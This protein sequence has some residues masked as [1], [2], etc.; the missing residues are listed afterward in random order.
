LL[1]FDLQQTGGPR[2]PV[3]RPTVLLADADPFVRTLLHKWLREEFETLS[4]AD[5]AEVLRLVSCQPPD[6]LLVDVALE[7]ISGFEICRS[8]RMCGIQAPVFLLSARI[9]PDE[10]AR[11][12]SLGATDFIAKPLAIREVIERVRAACAPGIGRPRDGV[13][14]A[15]SSPGGD[16][17]G[18]PAFAHVA[19]DAL[20]R[21]ARNRV[22]APDAFRERLA[23]ACRDVVRFGAS[24]GVVRI[25]WDDTSA[26]DPGGWLRGELE[27]LTRPEDLV[28][29]TSAAEAFVV[30]PTESRAGTIGFVRRLRREWASHRDAGQGTDCACPVPSD[31]R[32]GVG[33]VH[34]TRDRRP[35]TPGAVLSAPDP[36]EDL[37]ES[38][39]YA[40]ERPCVFPRD[41][42]LGMLGDGTFGP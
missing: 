18:E 28:T 16:G 33:V 7:R 11:G 27:R 42:K 22:L 32:V 4:A 37:F 21:A 30:L 14:T 29:L 5:G 9:D 1:Q 41:P 31:L 2:D 12:F 3:C 19:L 23:V 20:I 15:A 35:P 17:P 26:E 39:L 8:L 25:R 6:L 13:G 40:G 36:C 24:L 10:R 34:P 38:P